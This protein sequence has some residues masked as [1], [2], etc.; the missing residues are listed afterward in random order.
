MGGKILGKNL[1]I[2]ATTRHTTGRAR[3]LDRNDEAASED[4]ASVKQ[5]PYFWVLPDSASVLLT[6]CSPHCPAVRGQSDKSGMNAFIFR[7]K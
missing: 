7:T 1:H 3:A 5:T 6:S 4:P 2:T